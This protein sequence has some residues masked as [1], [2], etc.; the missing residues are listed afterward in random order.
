[1]VNN[2]KY[3]ISRK[4]IY[5]LLGLVIT[6]LAWLMQV[7]LNPDSSVS[8]EYSNPTENCCW[9]Y[10]KDGFN[11]DGLMPVCF[12]CACLWFHHVGSKHTDCKPLTKA[13]YEEQLKCLPVPNTLQVWVFSVNSQIF[14]FHFFVLNY[15]VPGHNP[16]IG[17]TSFPGFCLVGYFFAA[18]PE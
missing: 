13:F 8:V 1:M 18:S 15:S 2:G 6:N 4:D 14:F 16:V 11:S 17:F 7:Q 3:R 12:S 9:N 10:T 5:A